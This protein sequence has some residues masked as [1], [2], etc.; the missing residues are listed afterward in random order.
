M[1]SRVLLALVLF[2]IVAVGV[3]GERT[4]SAPAA[5]AVPSPP[6]ASPAPVPSPS[7]PAAPAVPDGLEE[8]AQ[9]AAAIMFTEAFTGVSVTRR[10]RDAAIARLSTPSLAEGLRY[11]ATDALPE[12]RVARAVLLESGES[13]AIVLVA[14]D[15]GASLAVTVVYEGTRWLA[16]DVREA[17]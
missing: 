12:G 13:E 1:R 17:A 11:A 7:T 15:G 10:G 8:S 6:A 2:A 9:V 16:A 4:D 14:L 5:G 3:F